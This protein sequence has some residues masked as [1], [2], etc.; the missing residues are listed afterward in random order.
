MSAKNRFENWLEE[1]F[2]PEQEE[3]DAGDTVCFDENGY[4][5]VNLFNM[6]EHRQMEG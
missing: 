1:I 5:L 3:T 2:E 4:D 6:A